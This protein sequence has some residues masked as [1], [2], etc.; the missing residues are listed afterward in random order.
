MPGAPPARENLVV[1]FAPA[2]GRWVRPLPPPA[3]SRVR[4][5][6]PN[7]ASRRQ[8]S[9]ATAMPAR[10]SALNQAKAYPCWALQCWALR[11][12]ALRC[13]VE[14][15]FPPSLPAVPETAWRRQASCVAIPSRPRRPRRMPSATIG[16]AQ[17]RLRP[18]VREI[19][20]RQK[21]RSLAKPRQCIFNALIGWCTPTNCR[22]WPVRHGIAAPAIARCLSYRTV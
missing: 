17:W 12:W 14:G 16:E 5:F 15:P 2:P 4:R 18:V 7:R 8:P 22:K 21:C 1:I 3:L 11:Y 10:F 19:A 13:P 20:R 9:S 6:G